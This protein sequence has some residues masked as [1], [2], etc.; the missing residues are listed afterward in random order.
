MAYMLEL[1]FHLLAQANVLWCVHIARLPHK[2]DDNNYKAFPV[3][4]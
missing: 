4:S 2:S 1:K 3:A